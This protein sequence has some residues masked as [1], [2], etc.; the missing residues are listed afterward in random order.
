MHYAIHPAG[1]S[2]FLM[3][4]EEQEKKQQLSA[5][6]EYYK[7]LFRQVC[8]SISIDERK[9]LNLQRNMLPLRFRPYMTEFS[10]K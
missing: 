4:G 3:Q 6:E 10:E 9:N 2:W 5:K 7:E 1:K 8:H